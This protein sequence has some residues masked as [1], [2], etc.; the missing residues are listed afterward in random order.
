MEIDNKEERFQRTMQ[1]TLQLEQRAM[2]LLEESDE[3]MND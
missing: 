1:R 2:N 3:E